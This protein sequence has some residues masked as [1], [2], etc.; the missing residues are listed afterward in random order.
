[1][2]HVLDLAQK[3]SKVT[4]VY[5]HVQ[6]NNEEAI[7]FYQRFGFEVTDRIEN[8]YKRIDPPHCFVLTKKLA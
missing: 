8:Y 3:D 7:K 5:L 6:I 2:S 1:M 4:Q